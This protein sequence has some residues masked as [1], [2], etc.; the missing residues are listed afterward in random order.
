MHGKLWFDEND[1]RTWLLKGKALRSWGQTDSYEET[2]GQLQREFANVLCQGVGQWWF[3]MGGGWYDDP[4]ILADIGAMNRIAESSLAWNRSTVDEVA[5]VVDDK[6][7]HLLQVGNRLSRPL[8]LEQLP[9]LGRLGAPIGFYS[10]GD[11]DKLP[12]RKMYVFL[13]VFAPT[14]AERRA[15][16]RLKGQGRVL[17]WIYA[18][19][20]YREGQLDLEGMEAL[21][22]VHLAMAS[23][24]AKLEVKTDSGVYGANFNVAPV[25]FAD[26]SRTTVLG[27]LAGGRAGLVCREMGEWT[28]VYSSAPKLPTTL[29]RQLAMKAGV[30]CYLLKP[31]PHDVI[32]ANHSLV[33]LCAS[34]PGTRRVVLPHECDVIDLFD[35]SK[36]IFTATREFSVTL[37]RNQTKLFRLSEAKEP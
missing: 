7:L 36:V 35:G 4:R 9:E 14:D 37:E 15:I 32:Y 1:Y 24:P 26:D 10:L 33:A 23:Q 30:H 16:D 19:G 31:E 6:S 8:L 20:V 2:R 27:R 34:E 12:P 17:V 22:G 18:P 3:D 11:L 25:F 29:L 21:T 13:N 28:T 5:V